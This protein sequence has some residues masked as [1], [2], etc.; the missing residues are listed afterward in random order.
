MRRK[1]RVIELFS[2]MYSE[3]L[4]FL[5]KVEEKL[6]NPEDY[7]KLLECLHTYRI[8]TIT[9]QELQASVGDLLAE[10][11]DLLEGFNDFLTQCD[12]NEGFLDGVL[13]KSLYEHH[14]LVYHKK[15]KKTLSD[16]EDFEKFLKCLYTYNRELITREE[17][18][19]LVEDLL[20]KHVDLMEGFNE[21]LTQCEE[22]ENDA[23]ELSEKPTDIVDDVE[24]SSNLS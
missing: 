11:A 21:F 6:G 10:H 4:A 24:G 16:P 19:A 13:N 3:A 5:E 23:R 9:R 18:H 14:V 1:R 7:Q 2:D 8:E 12:D 15:V 22:I 17:L 20:G